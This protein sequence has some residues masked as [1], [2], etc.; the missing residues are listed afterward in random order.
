M[1]FPH[2]ITTFPPPQFDFSWIL[3]DALVP[4]TVRR[5]RS[6]SSEITAFVSL[7]DHNFPSIC[8]LWKIQFVYFNLSLRQEISPVRGA[9][10]FVK[11]VEGAWGCFPNKRK[12]MNESFTHF[13]I[14]GHK[15]HGLPRQ[16]PLNFRSVLSVHFVSK[17][18][19]TSP[20][21]YRNGPLWLTPL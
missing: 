8:F 6:P 2:Y 13:L 10:N 15:K 12:W 5:R 7:T 18:P 9:A 17:P 11:I 3:N 20:L 19:T 21:K 1:P 4:K 14:F 16:R